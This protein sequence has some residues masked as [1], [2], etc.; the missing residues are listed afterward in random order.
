MDLQKIDYHYDLVRDFVP[1]SGIR[2]WTHIVLGLSIFVNGVVDVYKYY[3]GDFGNFMFGVG[4]FLVFT[5]IALFFAALRGMK[6][7]GKEG[8]LSFL[9][10]ENGELAFK[11]VRFASVRK[12]LL[13]RL[14]KI[15][16]NESRIIL[17]ER[18]KDELYIKL[19]QIQNSEKK[20]EF[21]GLIK[22]LKNKKL[23]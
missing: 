5:G 10:I 15:D 2:Y 20:E 23:K 17:K 6:P 19:T 16:V 9:K 1:L 4:L 14:E 12:I 7:I 11:P 18:G 21:V 8:K 13:D 22:N 3:I